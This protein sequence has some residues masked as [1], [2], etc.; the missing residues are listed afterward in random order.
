MPIEEFC[1]IEQVKQLTDQAAVRRSVLHA[2]RF[3]AFSTGPAGYGRC[4][5]RRAISVHSKSPR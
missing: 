1:R 2:E 5:A 4:S 3:A